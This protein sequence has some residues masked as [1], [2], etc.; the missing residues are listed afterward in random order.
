MYFLHIIFEQQR[1][2]YV[3]TRWCTLPVRRMIKWQ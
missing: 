1:R 2:Q 3:F